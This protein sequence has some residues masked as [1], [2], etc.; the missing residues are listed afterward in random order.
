MNQCGQP[1]VAPLI[2]ISFFSILENAASLTERIWTYF[3]IFE[4]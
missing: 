2:Q 3:S 4:K 1:T